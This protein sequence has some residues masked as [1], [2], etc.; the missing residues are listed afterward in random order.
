VRVK[1]LPTALEDID[2]GRR[3]YARQIKSLGDYFL[4]ALFSDID[5]LELFAG[6]HTLRCSISTSYDARYADLLFEV[7]AL[8]RHYAGQ[9]MRYTRMRSSPTPPPDITDIHSADPTF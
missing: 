5:S 7:I 8:E 9:L 6:I 3:F 1:I 4:D 2:R